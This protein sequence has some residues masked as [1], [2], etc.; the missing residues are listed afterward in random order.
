MWKAILTFLPI[1]IVINIDNRLQCGAELGK[2]CSNVM[3]L[4]H[5]HPYNLRPTKQPS[6]VEENSLA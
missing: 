5:C 3:S 4:S 1:M 6:R 2:K